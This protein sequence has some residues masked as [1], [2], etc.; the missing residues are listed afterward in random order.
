MALISAA[1]LGLAAMTSAVIA[2]TVV[3]RSQYQQQDFESSEAAINRLYQSQEAATARQFSAEE[4]QKQRD[5]EKEMAST[6]YQRAIADMKAAGINP[7]SI[8]MTSPA[9][10]PS[11]AA[12]SAGSVPQGSM[13][14]SGI[15]NQNVNYISSLFNSAVEYTMAKDRNFTNETIANM[16]ASNAAQMR[17]ASDLIRKTAYD[18]RTDRWAKQSKEFQNSRINKD[19]DN[20][21]FNNL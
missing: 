16:Y 17:H 10:V 9:A 3:P 1:I 11:G 8:G 7:A 21:N 12:A 4:A 5:F 20:M 6:Q 2:N 18:Y 13:G 19:I 14:H 15:A